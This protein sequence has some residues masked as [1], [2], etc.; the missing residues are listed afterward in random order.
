MVIL[1]GFSITSIL[2]LSRFQEIYQKLP[3][4]KMGHLDPIMGDD[5]KLH[6]KLYLKPSNQLNS[7][8]MDNELCYLENYSILSCIIVQLIFCALIL[9]KFLYIFRLRL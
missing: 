6:K 9:F 1:N 4:G 3:W 7:T 2:L 8:T 5:V